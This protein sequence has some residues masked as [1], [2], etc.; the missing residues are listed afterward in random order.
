MMA[1]RFMQLQTGDFAR[2]TGIFSS[3]AE[4]ALDHMRPPLG[5]PRYMNYD[6]S[7]SQAKA[8]T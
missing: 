7:M 3:C 1:A 8:R 6:P 2:A 5:T 4:A